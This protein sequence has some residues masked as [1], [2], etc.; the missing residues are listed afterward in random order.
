MFEYCQNRTGVSGEAK[1][2]GVIRCIGLRG[3]WGIRW[4][5]GLRVQTTIKTLLLG[6]LQARAF[7]R[8]DFGH[9]DINKNR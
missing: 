7:I 1:D 5:A 2:T 6:Q 9:F 8:N 4:A 3:D